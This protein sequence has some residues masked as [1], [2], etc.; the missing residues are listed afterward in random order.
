MTLFG[1]VGL[2]FVVTAF[3]GLYVFPRGGRLMRYLKTEAL[4][5]S[6]VLIGAFAFAVFA[7]ILGLH[8]I[9]G[10]FMAV[11]ISAARPLIRNAITA[12]NMQFPR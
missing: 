5:I 8:F 1:K 7:E 2:F 11:S 3:F 9:I 10:A 6:A 12:L 4:E